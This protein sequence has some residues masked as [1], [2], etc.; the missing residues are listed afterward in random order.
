MGVEREYI[1]KAAGIRTFAL[2]SLAACLFTIL[3]REAF[4]SFLGEPGISYDPSRMAGN[5]IMGI[6]FLGAGLIIFR[7][8]KIE[9]LTTAAG[10]WVASAVGMAVACRFYIIA[11][12][13]A[14]LVVLILAILRRFRI[15]QIL[16]EDGKG[17]E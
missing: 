17:I 5:V 9:G 16:G 10:L 4:T 12:F 13:T 3:S 6:G 2:V 8:I 1:G 15:D 14:F 7:G 11:I